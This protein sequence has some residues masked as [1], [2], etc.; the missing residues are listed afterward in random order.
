MQPHFSTLL[1]TSSDN[2]Q[3]T[4]KPWGW[5]ATM[6]ELP[7]H[8]IKHIGV[9]PGQRISLQKHHHRHEHWVVLQGL[10][11]VTL[12]E[13]TFNLSAGQHCDIAQG[14]A[15]RLANPGQ[16]PLLILEVQFGDY[17]GE[18]DIERLGDDYGRV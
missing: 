5:Y 12:G 2:S 15:H 16:Q 3:L 4:P 11:C 9:H 1:S 18:D 8:K 7:G 10:A 13:Q 14:L 6:S 17:L